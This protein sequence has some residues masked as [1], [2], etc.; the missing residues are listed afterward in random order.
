MA[1]L[2]PLSPGARAAAIV[3]RVALT[4][5]LTSILGIA[6]AGFFR[7]HAAARHFVLLAALVCALATPGFAIAFLTERLSPL[8]L[9]L[10]AHPR[11]S[12]IA[13]AGEN[14]ELSRPARPDPV[15]VPA[16]RSLD[17]HKS[18]GADAAVMRPMRPTSLITREAQES[19]VVNSP[20][21]LSA[22]NSL[23]RLAQ[24]G[25]T[26]AVGSLLLTVRVVR[27][28]LR[29]RALRRSLRFRDSGP[30]V[31]LL[32]EAR[33]LVGSRRL[34]RVAESDRVCTPIA[35]GIFRPVIV[36]PSGLSTTLG[37]DELLDVLVHESA[38]LVRGDQIVIVLQA[39]ARVAYWPIWPVHRLNRLLANAREEVCDN[40]VLV[41]QRAE[42]Y[43]ETLLR[44]AALSRNLVAFDSSSAMLGWRGPLE[45]RILELV[46]E[47]R[48]RS[49]RAKPIVAVTLATILVLVTAGLCGT[50][51]A[52]AQGGLPQPKGQSFTVTPV[53]N[54]RLIH[55]AG[56]GQDVGTRVVDVIDPGH[57]RAVSTPAEKAVAKL[58]LVFFDD[59]ARRGI[60]GIVL[61]AGDHSFVFTTTMATRVPD[62]LPPA[63][64]ATFLERAGKP[65]VEAIYDSRSTDEISVFRVPGRFSSY[66][67]TETATVAVGDVLDAAASPRVGQIEVRP[68][69]AN[70][71]AIKQ[72]VSLVLKDASVRHYTSLIEIDG[73][74]FPEGTPF[75]KDGKLVG[76]ALVGTRF[77]KIS[78]NL[79]YI[80]PAERMA[81][82]YQ[83]IKRQESQTV[84]PEFPH[85]VPFELG[86]TKFLK[87]DEI[88]ILEV[89]GTAK[90]FAPG[91]IYWIKG[92]YTLAS[93]D[94]AQLQ[95]SVTATES[96][97]AAGNWFKSQN[98]IVTQ[99][100]GT[101]TL[102]LPMTYTGFPHLSFYTV[103][104]GNGFGGVYFGTGNSVHRQSGDHGGDH[105]GDHNGDHGG[106]RGAEN[107]GV[108]RIW[109]VLG[110]RVSEL[111]RKDPRLTTLKYGGGLMITEVRPESPAGRSGLRKDDIIVGL[112][113]YA[114]PR[115]TDAV[116][117]LDQPRV[118]ESHASPLRFHIVRDGA[119]VFGH[120][121]LGTN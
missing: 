53:G 11:S 115:L 3:V 16:R 99:G 82:L 96:G 103:D 63:I 81:R 10:S 13:S 78:P 93:H 76:M 21:V 91:N 114:T 83:M 111:D 113:R 59:R 65:P 29:L 64:D 24:A 118:D 66:Q 98:L 94:Q 75:Y 74:G 17:S 15:S 88:T 89:R 104:G 45:D 117:I 92:T 97:A 47:R 51:L 101:F 70:V 79:S 72:E 5:G 48:N 32:E 55:V 7:H 95:A 28:S 39:I 106:N 120:L 22:G 61:D 41:R 33:R 49:T 121:K 9:R 112:D 36:L 38:H 87:D 77:S 6:V 54:D 73:G 109:D 90:T 35:A 105:G 57:L 40:Y 52:S 50:R 4:V 116:W 71:R 56:F 23:F 37:R 60:Y 44:V 1:V 20:D 27:G 34:P 69:T 84:A 119:L 80:V 62:D 110:A 14:Q 107:P 108:Q 46:S 67:F 30:I 19:P 43:G 58:M 8:V 85:A 2:D 18:V 26:L 42:Q 86:E 31:D 12:S 68:H 100:T 102:F 25:A